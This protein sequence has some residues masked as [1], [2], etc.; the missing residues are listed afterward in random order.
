MT[1]DSFNPM[2]FLLENY[3]NSKFEDLR[4]GLEYM[5]K[6][7]G[8]KTTNSTDNLLKNN[9]SSFM[10]AIKIM[11]DIHFLSSIDKKNEFTRILE[12]MLKGLNLNKTLTL[13]GCNFWTEH[14][15]MLSRVF[16][17]RESDSINL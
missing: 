13:R 15:K 2:R 7:I 6:N 5:K 12:S 16:F 14:P 1:K 9:I 11:K 10:D 3:Q 17:H 8:S 4:S